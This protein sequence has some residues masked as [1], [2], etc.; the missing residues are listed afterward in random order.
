VITSAAPDA[1]AAASA[2]TDP[3][4]LCLQLPITL[5][6][7]ET[8][9]QAVAAHLA[10]HGLPQRTLYLI[11][12]VLEELQMNLLMHGF[13]DPGSGQVQI[14]VRVAP[15]HVRLQVSDNGRPFDPTRFEPGEA[16][17]NLETARVGGL[18]LSLVR[19][20]THPIVYERRDGRN[21]LLLE[22]ARA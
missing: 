6:A 17:T 13:D 18:G 20:A 19:K 3:Q 10:P 7:V 16:P 8:A 2:V 15:Q 11:E 14:G 12:L 22:F 21:H 9:R 4:S 5:A 1:V